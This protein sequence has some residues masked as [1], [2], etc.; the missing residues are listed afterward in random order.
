MEERVWTPSLNVQS[1]LINIWAIGNPLID[2]VRAIAS[3]CVRS[4]GSVRFLSR[5]QAVPRDVIMPRGQGNFVPVA[6]TSRLRMVQATALWA[7]LM[8]SEGASPRGWPSAC[9]RVMRW[10]RGCGAASVAEQSAIRCCWIA[11]VARLGEI[12]SGAIAW[13]AE[14]VQRCGRMMTSTRRLRTRPSWVRF[15]PRGAR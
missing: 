8:E 15:S 12:F 9:A 10:S 13:R 4:G 3:A 7:R 1:I 2:G 6:R 5:A 11:A 14:A